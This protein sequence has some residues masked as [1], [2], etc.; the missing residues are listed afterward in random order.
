M[1]LDQGSEES[2]ELLDAAIKQSDTTKKEGI[3]II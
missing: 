3:Y 2:G 1:Q